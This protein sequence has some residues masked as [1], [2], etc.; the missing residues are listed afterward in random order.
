[1]KR[2]N[3]PRTMAGHYLDEKRPAPQLALPLWRAI[4]FPRRYRDFI[5]KEPK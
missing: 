1:M 4:P 2:R 3:D 5:W